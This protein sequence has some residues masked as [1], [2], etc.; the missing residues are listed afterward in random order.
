VCDEDHTDVELGLDAVDELE[1]LSLHRD[2]E[3][4][5]RL[6]RDEQVG[7]VEDRHRDHGALTH[8]ARVLVRIVVEAN[9]WVRDP[10]V[11]QHLDDTLLGLLLR[12]ALVDADRLDELVS[13]AIH[14]VQT[15]ERVLEDHGDLLAANCAH[16]LARSSEQVASLEEDLAGDQRPLGVVE[17]EDRKI[18]DA[19]ARPGLAD[20]AERLAAAHRERELVNRMH[21]SVGRRELDGEV[22]DL[23]Q[24]VAGSR[25]HWYRTL[26]SR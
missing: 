8:P 16:F 19:L 5:R 21:D 25:T 12:D 26:G 20:D 4:R 17:A 2:I 23:D 10:D 22:L 1:D 6:V 15:G 7:V 18:G 11:G 13:H 3:R 24:H 14:R 9:A